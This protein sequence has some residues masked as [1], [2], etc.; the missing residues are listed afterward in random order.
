M[1]TTQTPQAP[2]ANIFFTKS[3]IIDAITFTDYSTNDNYL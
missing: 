2:E 3:F 1:G